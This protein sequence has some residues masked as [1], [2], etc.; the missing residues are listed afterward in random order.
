MFAS[1]LDWAYRELGRDRECRRLSADTRRQIILAAIEDGRRIGD[2]LLD[3]WGNPTGKES[4]FLLVSR[5]RCCVREAQCLYSPNVLA[6]YDEATRTILLYPGNIDQAERRFHQAGGLPV[7]AV[8]HWTI[9]EMCLTH[10]LFHHL[11][12]TRY[13][14]T[15]LKYPVRRK[16]WGLLPITRTVRTIREIAAHAF[17]MRVL[18]LPRPPTDLQPNSTLKDECNDGSS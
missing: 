6:E 5:L 13:G 9:A 4:L 16:L 15:D 8:F 1:D 7:A 3:E 17:V 14:R 10:E 18:S 2:E 11:E 12:I